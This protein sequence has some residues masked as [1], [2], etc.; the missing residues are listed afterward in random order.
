MALTNN[1][2]SY[3]QRQYGI[4]N[5]NAPNIG[6]NTAAQMAYQA[7][8]RQQQAKTYDPNPMKALRD[9]D[10]QNGYGD[11]YAPKSNNESSGWSGGTI[12]E[13]MLN[14]MAPGPE[15]DA[16]YNTWRAQKDAL[17]SQRASMEAA[18][19]QAEEAQRK[20]EEARLNAFNLGKESL[21]KSSDEA[22]RQTFVQKRMA[23]RDL[24]QQ[25]ALQGSTGGMTESSVLGMNAGYGENRT[26]IENERQRGITDLSSQY[27]SGAAADAL[28]AA[29]NNQQWEIAMA[30]LAAQQQQ[31]E[32][33]YMM[34]AAEQASK[35]TAKVSS[36]QAK[37]TKASK[38]DLSADD[39]L[40]LYEKGYRGSNVMSALNYWM[41]NDWESKSNTQT[42][43]VPNNVKKW[44]G[45]NGTYNPT[46]AQAA[47]ND[48]RSSGMSLDQWLRV[49][50]PYLRSANIYDWFKNYAPR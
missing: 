22:L 2:N 30:N 1:A 12:T 48:Y 24:P 21:N 8:M 47:L 23:E 49:N 6:N 20:A 17:E 37:A 38:P 4:T 41:G 7:A 13:D 32:L 45:D 29:A 42:V 46:T 25:L 28:Q 19:R 3:W 14:Q 18:R 9:Y 34:W 36:T 26:L 39:A 50:E 35:N 31:A 40:A 15:Y 44:A 5:P 10:N 43:A 16:A 33:S 11:V 27:Q